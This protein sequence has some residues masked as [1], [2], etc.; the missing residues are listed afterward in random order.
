MLPAQSLLH[1]F[2]CSSNISGALLRIH[3]THS[4]LEV[5]AARWRIV[6]PLIQSDNQCGSCAEMFW[7]IFSAISIQFLTIHC[8]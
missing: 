1:D 4:D 6:L 2:E 3:F 8:N 7:E 5:T